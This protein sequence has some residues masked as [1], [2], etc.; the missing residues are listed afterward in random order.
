LTLFWLGFAVT[1]LAVLMGCAA[2]D[3]FSKPQPDRASDI[4]LQ[5]GIDYL[6]KDNLSEAK[7]KIERALS[8][9]PRNANAHATAGLLYSRIGDI[10]KADSHFDR[11]VSL[12]G[13]NPEIL[14]SYAAF[15]CSHGRYDRGEKI[16]LR[17]ATN[18]L[19][20][21]PEVAYLNAG[22]CARNG[23][24]LK[25][26]EE[27]YR[28]AL[29]T[30]PRFGAAL[31]QMADLEYAQTEYLSARAFL[32]RYLTVARTDASTLWLAVRIERSLGNAIA[33]KDYARRLKNDYPNAPET[34]ELLESE[35]QPG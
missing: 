19:Y 20:K 34:R 21:T 15:L 3:Q 12:D 10:D 16:A 14:N 25:S 7:E 26:A 11:A 2:T 30:R 6:R 31:F 27:N 28:R 13:E 29:G 5:L 17:A 1:P 8:Q 35:R 23:G 9:N 18:Q 32:E 24:K 4:N 33:A 22:N